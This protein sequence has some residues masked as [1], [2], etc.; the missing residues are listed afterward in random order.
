MIN[1]RELQEGVILAASLLKVVDGYVMSVLITNEIEIKVQEPV[2]ELD[3]VESIWERG[4]GTEL[5]RRSATFN[6]C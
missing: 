1:K 6:H 3:E 4:C 2:V 5:H